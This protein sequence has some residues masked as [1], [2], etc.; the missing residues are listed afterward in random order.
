[1]AINPTVRDQQ[2]TALRGAFFKKA[3]LQISELEKE[4]YKKE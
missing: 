2:S 1:M 4:A 3:R